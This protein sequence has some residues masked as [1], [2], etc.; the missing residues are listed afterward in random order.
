MGDYENKVICEKC[1]N[2]FFAEAN[3]KLCERCIEELFEEV[4][5]YIEEH[6]DNSIQ[7]I[8]KETGI[9][10]KHI[11]RWI[12]EGR[13]ELN[14]PEGKAEKHKAAAF[15]KEAQKLFQEKNKDKKTDTKE[16][17]TKNKEK[18]NKTPGYHIKRQRD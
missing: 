16:E 6:P 7:D 11:K 13:L 14:T 3:K 2:P 18:N 17:T 10:Q 4:K 12:R 8:A 15:K 1:K 5:K 9:E